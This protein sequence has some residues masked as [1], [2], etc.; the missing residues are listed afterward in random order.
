VVETGTQLFERSSAIAK[1]VAAGDLA[2]VGATYHLADG[3]VVIRNIIGDV[4]DKV[5]D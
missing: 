3:R 5:D 2:I 1:A 4:G